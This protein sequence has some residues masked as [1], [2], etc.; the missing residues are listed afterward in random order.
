MTVFINQNNTQATTYLDTNKHVVGTT[1]KSYLILK[2]KW[3]PF[4]QQLKYFIVVY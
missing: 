1:I 2:I 3:V 4:L